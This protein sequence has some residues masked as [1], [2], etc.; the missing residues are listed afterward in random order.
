MGKGEFFQQMVLGKL[1]VSTNTHTQKCPLHRY[2]GL[3]QTNS[4]TSMVHLHM[5][6]E[7]VMK[8][9]GVP[10][11]WQVLSKGPSAMTTIDIYTAS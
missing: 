8:T 4:H 9:H 6:K 2:Q 1:E 10:G 11:T 3:L 5:Y 7:V